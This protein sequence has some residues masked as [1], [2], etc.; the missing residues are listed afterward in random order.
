MGNQTSRVNKKTSRVNKETSMVNKEASREVS[1]TTKEA[2]S[3]ETSREPSTVSS[4]VSA[5]PTNL[6]D[7]T[8]VTL[9]VLDL[10][11]KDHLASSLE[12]SSSHHRTLETLTSE[13]TTNGS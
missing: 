5:P 7:K 12:T 13:A 8:Q 11:D 4:L 9:L 2:S 3:K 10:V 1:V 6:E